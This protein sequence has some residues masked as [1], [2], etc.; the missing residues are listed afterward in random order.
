MPGYAECEACGNTYEYKTNPGKFCPEHR[1]NSPAGYRR[2]NLKSL[3]GITV[4]EYDELLATQDGVCAL[5]FRTS[6]DGRR[7]CV[8][9]CHETGA[10][11]GLLCSSCN[12]SI[13]CLGDTKESLEKV[14]EYLAGIPPQSGDCSLRR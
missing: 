3:Y 9:H 8:D 2:S 12:Y 1:W 14:V 11:R 6:S 7:L 13:G 10:I 5:C 4:E